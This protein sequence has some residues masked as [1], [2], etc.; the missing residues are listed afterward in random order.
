MPPARR[1]SAEDKARAS[2]VCS[3]QQ[4]AIILDAAKR[5][6]CDLNTFVLTHALAGAARSAGS[7]PVASPVIINGAVGA[8]LRA[9]AAEQGVPPERL[10]EMLLI[11]QGG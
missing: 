5:A 11:A 6:G 7:D 9:R 2:L 8:K 1:I 10:V 4:K 3:R